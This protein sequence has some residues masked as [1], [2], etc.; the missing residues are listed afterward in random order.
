MEDFLGDDW[1]ASGSYIKE[2]QLSPA[3]VELVERKV[4]E[5]KTY[6]MERA[7]VLRASCIAVP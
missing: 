7:K 5:R 2:D 3:Q 6:E 4:A 1:E